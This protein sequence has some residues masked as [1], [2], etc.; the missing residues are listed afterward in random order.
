MMVASLKSPLA[1]PP[2]GASEE[3]QR[4]VRFLRSLE[5]RIIDV[6][7]GACFRSEDLYTIR[8]SVAG[9]SASDHTVEHS[10][11][12]FLRLHKRLQ[13]WWAEMN[14]MPPK[15]IFRSVLVPSIMVERRQLLSEF[16]AA[17]CAWDPTMANRDLRSFLGV[18]VPS[19]LEKELMANSFVGCAE[20]R[21][22]VQCVRE[23]DEITNSTRSKWSSDNDSASFSSDEDELVDIPR[24]FEILERLSSMKAKNEELAKENKIITNALVSSAPGRG[25]FDEVSFLEKLNS[26]QTPNAELARPS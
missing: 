23:I 26:I 5:A 13:P 20:E 3:S 12:C 22:F 25:S 2:R 6:N 21:S 4:S 16:L 19:A 7:S 8:V 17:A 15:S 18:D 10:Y 11:S 14:P 1:H 24:S 9:S